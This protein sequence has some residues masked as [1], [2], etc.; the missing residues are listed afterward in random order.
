[1]NIKIPAKI[2]INFKPKKVPIKP[3]TNGP[4]LNQFVGLQTS[5]KNTPT[6][7]GWTFLT[8]IELIDG[9]TPA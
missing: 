7:F 2:K 5:N 6:L 3:P 1:M 9:Y 8:K 4:I